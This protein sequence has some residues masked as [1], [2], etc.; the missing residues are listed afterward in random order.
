MHHDGQ[1]VRSQSAAVDR[2]QHTKSSPIGPAEQEDG[3][4]L[5][6]ENMSADGSS[7][8]G[9]CATFEAEEKTPLLSTPPAGWA[10]GAWRMGIRTGPGL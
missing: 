10:M 2:D 6:I 3:G 9:H 7:L 8:D 1:D 4:S 5:C